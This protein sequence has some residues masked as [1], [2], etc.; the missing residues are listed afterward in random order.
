ME[1]SF[2]V[3]FKNKIKLCARVA[4]RDPTR[5]SDDRHIILCIKVG[6]R[7][8]QGQKHYETRRSSRGI[9]GLLTETCQNLKRYWCKMFRDFAGWGG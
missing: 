3:L 1:K 2:L 6:V 5:S 8:E 4:Q 9:W 7:E